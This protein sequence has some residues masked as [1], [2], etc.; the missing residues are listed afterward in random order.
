MLTEVTESYAENKLQEYSEFTLNLE[1]MHRQVKEFR[2]QNTL[3]FHT[4]YIHSNKIATRVVQ[5]QE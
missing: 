4:P 5:L 1:C 2:I 3:N